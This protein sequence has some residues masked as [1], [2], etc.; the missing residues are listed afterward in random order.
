MDRLGAPL[1]ASLRTLGAPADLLSGT[2]QRMR[3]TVLT[4]E[5][6]KRNDRL[7]RRDRGGP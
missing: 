3:T 2:K 4:E 6:V 7:A 5:V 1:V